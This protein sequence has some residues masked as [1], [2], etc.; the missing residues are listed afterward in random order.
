MNEPTKRRAV[1]FGAAGLAAGATLGVLQVLEQAIS[2]WHPK[3]LVSSLIVV[4]AFFAGLWVAAVR[5]RRVASSDF[6]ARSK[7]LSDL[8]GV[9]PAPLVRGADPCRIGVF[10]TRR[11][12]DPA[13][14]YAPRR[15]DQ[16]LRAAIAAGA[17]VMVCGDR[18]AGAS[19]TAVEAVR[20]ALG[21][22]VILAPR[23]A[24]ALRELTELDPPLQL[25]GRHVLVWLDGL[26]RFIESLDSESLVALTRVGQHVTVVA[27][28]RGEHWDEWL[29]ATG[30]GGEAAR[31]FAREARVFEL[32]AGLT[33]DELAHA[34]QLYP[35]TDFTDGVGVALAS[36]GR[37]SAPPARRPPESGEC[38]EAHPNPAVWRDL[39]VVAPALLTCA[40][41]ALLASHARDFQTQSI[42]DQIAADEREGS[43]HERH[44]AF[45]M[46]VD[47]HG[48]GE[49]S[50]LVLFRDD[51]HARRRRSDEIRIY[52]QHGEN[53]VRA[54]RFEPVGEPAVF[55]ERAIAN[56]DFDGAQDIVGGYGYANESNGGGAI[57]PFAIDWDRS[58]GRYV[59]LSLQEGEKAPTLSGKAIKEAEKQY[60]AGGEGQPALKRKA[61]KIAEEQYQRVYA[62]RTTFSDPVDHIEITGHRV[63]D[64]AVS[65]A[66][67]RLVAGWYLRPLLDTHRAIF[68]LHTAIFDSSTG[69]PHLTPCTFTGLRGPLTVRAGKDRL[70]YRTFEEA[71]AKVSRTRACGPVYR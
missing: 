51:P 1:A 54:L 30:A 62:S 39:K 28:I 43:H 18:R 3:P 49:K 55:Q 27:T 59:V 48:S 46:Q 71:Y 63:Q 15:I 61:V 42:T 2:A 13:A 38:Q 7:H 50:W 23:S 68:E 10:P 26:D 40:A 36:R 8:V 66:P 11:D 20:A 14:P 41:L 57:V 45:V 65:P 21:E 29:E 64:L 24:S 58:R 34:Q 12:I 52:D 44:A 31:A 25:G 5:N 69:A 67:H 17:V 37:D 35:R 53:L 6:D 56:V 47:L 9:W 33:R 22:A 4:A 32:R 19:R 70:A 16:D 60:L